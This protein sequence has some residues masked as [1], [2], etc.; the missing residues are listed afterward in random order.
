MEEKDAD[1]IT[2]L[3]KIVNFATSDEPIDFMGMPFSY[4]K[5]KEMLIK[6]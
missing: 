1:Y 2:L 3:E 6:L 5:V 4:E